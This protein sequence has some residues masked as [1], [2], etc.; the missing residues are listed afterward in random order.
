[1]I[2]VT[3]GSGQLGT[4]FRGLLP[5]ARFPNRSELD[6]VDTAAIGPWVEDSGAEAVINC[7]AYTA[8]DAAETDEETAHLVNAEAVE[9]MAQVCARLGI[10]LV[11][12]STDYVFDGTKGGPYVEGDVTAPL[13][14]Y[15]RTKRD[16]ER[17]ALAA[18]PGALVVRSSWVISGTHPNF[19][20]TM[21]RLA[22][23]GG[24]RVVDDQHGCPTVADDLAATT[25]AALDAGVSGILHLT[26]Q[27][28]TTWHGLAAE[29]VRLAGLDPTLVVPCA[30]EEFPRPAPRPAYSVLAS[31]RRAPLGLPD[32]PHWKDS[33][34]EVVASQIA[35]G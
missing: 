34:P 25:L 1:M 12:F 4:A 24:L 20:A 27:G 17:R 18:H 11:T 15:G 9:E 6:L 13:N 22:R 32:L 30:T 35:R 2:V 7:A 28:V 19:V 14:A 33:L 10:P 23:S 26:N 31:E 29:S 5:G 16:G 3:G 8:V 21:L